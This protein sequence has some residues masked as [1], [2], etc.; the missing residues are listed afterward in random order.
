L[1][2]DWKTW[3]EDNGEEPETNKKLKRRLE[4][5]QGLRFAHGMRGVIAKGIQLVMRHAG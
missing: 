5:L 4:K 3:C 1:F 2:S